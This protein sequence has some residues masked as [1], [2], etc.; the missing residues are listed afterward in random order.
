MPAVKTVDAFIDSSCVWQTEA[1][2][3][4]DIL[5]STELTEGIKWGIPC[6]TYKGK[7]VVGLCA[8]K[9]YFGLWFYQG[10][11]LKDPNS[12][13]VNAQQGKTKALR[14]WRMHDTSDIKP[15]VIK[16]Y[17]KEAV[18]L[19]KNDQRI[20]P[21]R[22]KPVVIPT[23]LRAAISKHKS[24][25]KALED[26]SISCRREYANYVAEAKREDTRV[27]RADKVI[28]MIKDGEGLHDKYRR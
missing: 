23:E 18:Q 11:L 12:V 25:K 1:K 7:N 26:M 10:A 4:R 3:L 16:R 15:A 8:F 5:R 27:R 19:V 2:K 13:L 14:Q 24:A 9:S 17:V 28:K 21:S 22:S 20:S 6:Y